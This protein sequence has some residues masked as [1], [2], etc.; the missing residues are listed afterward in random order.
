MPSIDERREV[1]ARLRE[2]VAA[3]FDDG[4]FYD[5]CEVEDVLGLATD[6]G[7]W[8]E[9]AGVRRLADL[10]ELEERTCHAEV[11]SD[12][13]GAWV[14]CCSECDYDL[15]GKWSN[16]DSARLMASAQHKC[17]RFCPNCGS[18]LVSE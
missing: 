1:S 13:A 9:A 4:E 8:F 5:R 14:I 2:L 6:D 3:D 10:I 7:A 18:K 17:T 11:F 12:G 16:L 15:G